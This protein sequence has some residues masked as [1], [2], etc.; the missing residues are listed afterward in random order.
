MQQKNLS[1]RLKSNQL[2]TIVDTWILVDM[3]STNY[4]RFQ[5]HHKTNILGNSE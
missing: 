2:W 5:I 1:N 3:I 4:K